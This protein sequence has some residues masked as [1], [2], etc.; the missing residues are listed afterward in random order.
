MLC[1]YSQTFPHTKCWISGFLLSKY[2]IICFAEFI[3]WIPIRSIPYRSSPCPLHLPCS[4]HSDR[5]E[6]LNVAFSQPLLKEG[7]VYQRGWKSFL[8]SIFVFFQDG[9]ANIC[10]PNM[11]PQILFSLSRHSQN[12]LSAISVTVHYIFSFY[13]TVGLFVWDLDHIGFLMGIIL[14]F[15]KMLSLL[16]C[17]FC[18]PVIIFSCR[19]WWIGVEADHPLCF[20]LHSSGDW[21]SSW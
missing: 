8:H 10:K 19:G 5:P 11:N 20:M 6:C 12:V 7:W 3:S 21:A 15:L 14:V 16:S 18:S 13:Q 2:R 17:F 9:L 1:C 4:A